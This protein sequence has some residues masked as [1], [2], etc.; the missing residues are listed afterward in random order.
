LS[1]LLALA[2]RS[3]HDIVGRMLILVIAVMFVSLAP[4]R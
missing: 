4:R 2:T 3:A 1:G